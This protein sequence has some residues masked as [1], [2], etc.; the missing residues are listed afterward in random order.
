VWARSIIDE[1][2]D[3]LAVMV[4]NLSIMLD[5]DVIVVGG[6]TITSSDLAIP[7]LQRIDGLLPNQPKI[8]ASQLGYRAT[9]L[10]AVVNVLHNTG[11]FY[12]LHKLS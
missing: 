9:V 2:L 11:D 5:P 8:V 1:A 12:T 7:V 4:A 6:G 3:H 10:G